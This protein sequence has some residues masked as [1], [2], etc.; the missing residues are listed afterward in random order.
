MRRVSDSICSG[1]SGSWST[2]NI[3]SPLVPREHTRLP[4]FT[5][6]SP[7]PSPLVNIGKFKWEGPPAALP[8]LCSIWSPPS[9][10]LSEVVV[11]DGMGL[12]SSTG[13]TLRRITPV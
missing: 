1:T 13:N 4:I 12:D 3:A 6:P 11:G 8:S 10:E 2:L 5:P 9:V 7:S